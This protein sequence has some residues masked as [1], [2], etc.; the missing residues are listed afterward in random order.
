MRITLYLG[1]KFTAFSPRVHAKSQWYEIY[2]YSKCLL[3]NTLKKKKKKILLQ[4]AIAGK[5]EEEFEPAMQRRR[6]LQ[7]LNVPMHSSPRTTPPRTLLTPGKS[8]LTPGKG[9]GGGHRTPVK[10]YL[11][12]KSHTASKVPLTRSKTPVQTTPKT[13]PRATRTTPRT[14]PRFATPRN[15]FQLNI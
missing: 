6:A 9:V 1:F 13:T 12:P 14:L 5:L 15:R 7:E 3:C 8:F 10:S 11:T 4:E 2:Y